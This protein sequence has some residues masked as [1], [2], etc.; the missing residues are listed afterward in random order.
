MSEKDSKKWIGIRAI[1]KASDS[2]QNIQTE[3]IIELLKSGSLNRE[4]ISAMYK[5]A[6]NKE[7]IVPF[8]AQ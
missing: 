3:M 2:I 4:A 7:S 1:H 6:S 8:N 5:I